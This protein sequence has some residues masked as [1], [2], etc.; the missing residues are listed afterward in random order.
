MIVSK[1]YLLP[2]VTLLCL[3]VFPTGTSTATAPAAPSTIVSADSSAHDEFTN[4]LPSLHLRRGSSSSSSSSI[5]RRRRREL[6]SSSSSSTHV[7]VWQK[8]KESLGLFVVGI[9]L[10]VCS[11][12]FMWKNEGRHVVA[13]KKIEYCK[14]E[15]TLVDCQSPSPE[16][17]GKLVHF[18]GNVTTESPLEFNEGGMNITSP[19][20]GALILKRTC[21]IYQKFE[22]EQ[23]ETQSDVIGGGE[24]RTTTYT[25][26]EDWATSPQPD[27]E[28]L[29][30]TNDSGIW[31]GLM[32]VC[33]DEP[34]TVVV[35]GDAHAGGFGLSE[36]IINE[37]PSVFQSDAAPLDED[38]IPDEVDGLAGL[39]NFN[40]QFQTYYP[41]EGPQNGDVKVVY[42]YV[43]E[44]FDC[45]FVVQQTSG[46]GE[47]K[48]GVDKCDVKSEWCCGQCEDEL[49]EIWMVR[50]G[51]YTLEEMVDMAQEE[52]NMLVKILRVVCFVALLAGWSM[53]FSPLTT[54]LS[55]LPILKQLGNAAFFLVA[56]IFSC[57]CFCSVTAVAY[58]RYRPAVA[59][60]ILAV[61][62]IITGIVIWRLDV[63]ANTP[64][65]TTNATH[66]MPYLLPSDLAITD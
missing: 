54:I 53:L 34:S 8:F 11:P 56:L 27:C 29:G 1:R 18:I 31:S 6:K 25:L 28:N 59:F 10:I 43:A 58:I 51:N 49:G 5:S 44:G 50:K 24:T 42:E 57:V 20:P 41:D 4:V 23:N 62:G 37:Y 7:N 63:A 15:A 16:E 48:Y 30:E 26:K 60:G 2:F 46:N 13:L 3:L 55:T 17:N 40:N 22:I 39:M 35:S 66:F 61:A 9:I 65:P 45:T 64:I 36:A 12:V 38:Y 33:G 14:N 52:E 47:D 32:E 19:I 21:Y